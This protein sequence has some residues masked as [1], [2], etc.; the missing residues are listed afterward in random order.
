MVELGSLSHFI[1]P[2]EHRGF[3]SLVLA[4][5]FG[6]GSTNSTEGKTWNIGANRR[7]QRVGL[8]PEGLVI[9]MLWVKTWLGCALGCSFS[10]HTMLQW[11]KENWFAAKG[12][13]Q[14]VIALIRG[15]FTFNFHRLEHMHLVLAWNWSMGH[16]PF[17]IKPENPLFDAS[18]ER[19]DLVRL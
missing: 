10:I 12:I 18:R 2:E 11:V 16:A 8:S 1:R 5:G 4:G 14:E 15:W 9:N 13:V 6:T 3:P 19:V 17:F 7:N